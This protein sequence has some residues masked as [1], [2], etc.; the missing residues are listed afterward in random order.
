MCT[1]FQCK[2]NV[3]VIE[4]TDRHNGYQTKPWQFFYHVKN[5][6]RM[7][8]FPIPSMNILIILGSNDSHYCSKYLRKSMWIKC[9]MFCWLLAYHKAPTKREWVFASL[10]VSNWAFPPFRSVIGPILQYLAH[11]KKITESRLF[12]VKITTYPI[13]FLHKKLWIVTF[14]AQ[15]CRSSPSPITFCGGVGAFLFSERSPS[16]LSLSK[17]LIATSS[18]S[19]LSSHLKMVHRNSM[20]L[21]LGKVFLA[22]NIAKELMFSKTPSDARKKRYHSNNSAWKLY[23]LYSAQLGI[24]TTLTQMPKHKQT[25]AFPCMSSYRIANLGHHSYY[26]RTLNNLYG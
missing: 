2:S 11:Q 1:H 18:L 14:S 21:L 23:I 16:V 25:A 13:R 19:P 8:E 5:S 12:R 3:N 26:H 9:H 7:C 20:I 22:I 24:Q 15:Y 6:G 4:K 10:I 17:R